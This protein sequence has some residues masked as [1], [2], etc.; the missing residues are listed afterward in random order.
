VATAHQSLSLEAFLA[1]PEEKPALEYFD[2]AVTQKVTPKARHSRLQYKL[3]E[4]VNRAAEPS[5]LALAFPELRATFAGASVVPDVAVYH[6]ERIPRDADG[7]LQDDVFEPPD[8]AIEI[9]SPGQ[10]VNQLRR[11]CEWYVAHGVPLALLVDPYAESVTA[12]RPNSPPRS[13]TSAESVDCSDVLPGFGF[14]ARD[15]FACLR[16]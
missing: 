3:A 9:I 16:V 2:G 1:L 8:V 10:R 14:V 6:W 7:L 5:K 12:F 15:L 13:H 11:R 4:W